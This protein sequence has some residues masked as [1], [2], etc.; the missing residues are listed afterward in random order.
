MAVWASSCPTRRAC[1]TPPT[2]SASSSTT[3]P[4]VCRTSTT[5]RTQTDLAVVAVPRAVRRPSCLKSDKRVRMR[6]WNAFLSQVSNRKKK[7][8]KLYPPTFSRSRDYSG[9][10]NASS[11][12]ESSVIERSPLTSSSSS[13]VC[14]RRTQIC[15][16]KLKKSSIRISRSRCSNIRAKK[17][18]PVRV[19]EACAWDLTT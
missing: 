6:R 11:S 2:P 16:S 4:R 1:S 5:K 8:S 15:S 3:R 7:S 18:K 10:L 19:A 12:I 9:D 17:S 13:T 14:T